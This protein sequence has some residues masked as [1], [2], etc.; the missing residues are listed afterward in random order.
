MDQQEKGIAI[1]LDVFRRADKNDDGALSWEEFKAFFADGVLS[2]KELRDLFNEIDTHNTNNIDTEELCLY[3]SQ[4]LGA[5]RDVLSSMEDLNIAV[6]K[7]LQKS[8]EGYP[9][10]EF[11]EQFLTR[12]LLRELT[13]Q[14]HALQRP[15]D[16]ASD[17]LD[18]QALLLRKEKEQ[19]SPSSEPQASL[20]E[21]TYKRS[22]SADGPAIT[23]GRHGRRMRRLYNSGWQNGTDFPA[24][25]YA[26]NLGQQVDRLQSLIDK[27]EK[28]V[29]LDVQEEEELDIKEEKMLMLVHTRMTVD[30]NQ[31]KAFRSNLKNYVEMTN[32][33]PSCLHLGIRSYSGTNLFR[34]YEIWESEQAWRSHVGTSEYRTFQHSKVDMLET[35]EQ[36]STMPIPA[37]WWKQDE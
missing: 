11:V 26:G 3:F 33:E 4:H 29:T 20:D 31:L 25:K 12:F 13:N 7:A 5:F 18:E 32:E 23:A 16:T 36:V 10:S 2:E 19:C 22:I 8:A 6:S 30:G 17:I 24:G 27:L 14:L 15:V 28:K 34:V 1:F 21:P 35:P 9:A 37:S